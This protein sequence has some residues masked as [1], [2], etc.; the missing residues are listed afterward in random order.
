MNLHDFVARKNLMSKKSK[1]RKGLKNVVN[2][3][4]RTLLSAK[5]IFE[6]I[7]TGNFGVMIFQKFDGMI[8]HE[9]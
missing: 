5:I 8:F 2:E 1:S 3:R 6:L 7:P 9:F 4:F